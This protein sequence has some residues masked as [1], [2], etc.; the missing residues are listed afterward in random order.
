MQSSAGMLD[1]VVDDGVAAL[2][3]VQRNH[4]RKAKYL[5]CSNVVKIE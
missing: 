1:G 5:R 4:A 3:G 2:I